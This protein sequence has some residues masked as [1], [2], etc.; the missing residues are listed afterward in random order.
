MLRAEVV[1]R[2]FPLV[3]LC[4]ATSCDA[5]GLVS[6]ERLPVP[7]RSLPAPSLAAAGEGPPLRIGYD[8][9]AVSHAAAAVAGRLISSMLM[10]PAEL[11]AVSGGPAAAT[12]LLS[13]A[14]LHVVIGVPSTPPPVGAAAASVTTI[15]DLGPRVGFGYFSPSWLLA[16]QPALTSWLGLSPPG[17]STGPIGGRA[18]LAA[19]PA[20]GAPGAP[21]P[22]TVCGT[23]P[24][25]LRAANISVACYVEPSEGAL[26]NDCARLSGNGTGFLALMQRP[27]F[28]ST[29]NV[30]QVLMPP[31]CAPAAPTALAKTAWAELDAFFPPAVTFM[32]RAMQLS[33]TDAAFLVTAG[34][35]LGNF[36]RA[37]NAWLSIATGSTAAAAWM[38]V[39]RVTAVAPSVGPTAG[40][41]PLLLGGVGF[42]LA[43]PLSLAV[44]V[45]GAACVN[46]T[47]ISD[48]AI[49]CVSP[50]GIGTN[51]AASRSRCV[52]ASLVSLSRVWH[53]LLFPLHDWE[54]NVFE[55]AYALTRVT[56]A[57][58]WRRW[59]RC[60]A[61]IESALERAS[62]PRR[63]V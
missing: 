63:Y 27:S 53:A 20:G 1:L 47:W 45:G 9:F 32:L 12:A 36:S 50:P 25:G 4:I 16:A 38:R 40:A 22:S 48:S 33:D 6:C 54:W 37:A 7:Q 43:Q 29:G 59:G 51:N 21:G 60:A 57:Y 46:A 42:G 52:M 30:T 11:C 15:G 5:L 18:L 44:S 58:V 14:S 34:G 35:P 2:M 13:N 24:Q 61:V 10:Y 39:L 41:T 28:G 17:G 8:G 49:T 26:F 3:L 31:C 19:A 23:G 62:S 55:A 56:F